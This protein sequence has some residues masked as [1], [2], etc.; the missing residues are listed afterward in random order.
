MAEVFEKNGTDDEYLKEIRL[1]LARG[2]AGHVATT[3]RLM[4]VPD[5]Y[6]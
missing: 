4:N 6:G 1:P 5:A 3:A 2:I